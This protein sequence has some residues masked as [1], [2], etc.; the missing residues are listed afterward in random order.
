MNELDH[1]QSL[2]EL[3]TLICQQL[4]CAG[5]LITQ[6][7]QSQQIIL[8]NSGLGLPAHFETSQPLSH[9]ICQHT[10]A[11]DFPLVIDSTIVHPLLR[12]NKAFLDLG[13]AAYLGAPVHVHQGLATGAICA[14]ELRQRRWTE[15]DVELI[16]L[17]A[18]AADRLMAQPL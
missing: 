12:E 3:A 10:V 11:M 4:N 14:L 1:A 9:S 17:A 13:I 15:Q 8:A 6:V 18:T 7:T 2:G 16:M 5:T